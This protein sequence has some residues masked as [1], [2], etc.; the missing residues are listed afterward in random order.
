MYKRYKI[1]EIKKLEDMTQQNSRS[2]L[3]I[4]DEYVLYNLQ[5]VI[6]QNDKTWRRY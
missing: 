5:L 4:Y 2:A 3:N 1:V 6:T